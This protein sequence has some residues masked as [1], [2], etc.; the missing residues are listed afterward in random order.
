MSSPERAVSKLGLKM[1][2]LA[3]KAAKG[4]ERSRCKHPTNCSHTSHADVQTAENY[5]SLSRMTDCP[6][7]RLFVD[8][9]SEQRWIHY[10][11]RPKQHSCTSTHLIV[12]DDAGAISRQRT[13]GIADT[14]AKKG[15][16]PRLFTLESE[17]VSGWAHVRERVNLSFLL[18]PSPAA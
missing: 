14:A 8:V 11:V 9:I 15:P 4:A 3:S 13:W 12:S 10:I 6:K 17:R 16:P 18:P 2:S 5:W 7:S 1:S